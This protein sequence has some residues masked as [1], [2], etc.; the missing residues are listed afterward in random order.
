MPLCKPYKILENA[1]IRMIRM[2]LLHIKLT[3]FD[4]HLVVDEASRPHV[5]KLFTKK[6]DWVTRHE[7]TSEKSSLLQISG[8][9]KKNTI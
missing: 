6:C 7:D 9:H 8:F 5:N 4:A 2:V 3:P 1:I